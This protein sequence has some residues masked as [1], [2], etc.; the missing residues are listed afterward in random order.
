[1]AELRTI[2]VTHTVYTGTLI[3]ECFRD[4]PASSIIQYT[5]M[6]P[7]Q[8]QEP[9]ANTGMHRDGRDGSPLLRS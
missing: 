7:V 3:K 4:F 5:H 9:T 2:V 8:Y 6:E 1:M